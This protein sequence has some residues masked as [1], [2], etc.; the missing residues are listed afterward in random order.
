MSMECR[1]DHGPDKMRNKTIGKIHR[2]RENLKK[3]EHLDKYLKI[4]LTP[5]L[6]GLALDINFVAAFVGILPT[7]IP[8]APPK[9]SPNGE[10]ATL[11][12]CQFDGEKFSQFYSYCNDQ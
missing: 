4:S 7:T 8:P 10:V 1:V 3:E 5:L 6:I 9:N 12:G 2:G 11:R